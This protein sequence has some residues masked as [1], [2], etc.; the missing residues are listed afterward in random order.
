MRP[1]AF[2]YTRAGSVD[3]AVEALADGGTVLAGG[4]ALLTTMKLRQAKPDHLV[5]VNGLSELAGIAS[6]N[7][8]IVIG[9]LTRVAD[10]AAS[11]LLRKE[12]PALADAAS[13]MADPQ[14]R[15]RA[16]IAGN[17]CFA[18]PRA[19]LTPVLMALDAEATLTSVEGTS[20]LPAEQVPVAFRQTSLAPDQLVTSIRFERPAGASGCYQELARQPNGQ[21]IVNVSLH[22][23][24]DPIERAGVAVGGL[25]PTTV[26]LQGVEQ[27]LVGQSLDEPAIAAAIGRI[28]DEPLEPLDD[29]HAPP[30]YRLSAARTLLRRCLETL[31]AGSSR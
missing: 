19:N 8:K 28:G 22:V 9:G 11:E 10:I 4:Q 25:A 14:V 13:K 2:R 12:V 16:T 7:G 30:G 3:E 17:L 6:E 20:A 26:R 15:R 27:A 24:G 18:D 21:P 5:D 31:A 23:S 1:A 29:L